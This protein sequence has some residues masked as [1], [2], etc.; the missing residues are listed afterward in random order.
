LIFA[1]SFE[2]VDGVVSADTRP[3]TAPANAR[4]ALNISTS[5]FAAVARFD[6]ACTDAAVAASD[7]VC[8]PACA[9]PTV[10][11]RPLMSRNMFPFETA[12]SVAARPVGSGKAVGLT[13]LTSGW[14]NPSALRFSV[15]AQG[16]TLRGRSSDPWRR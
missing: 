12:C 15:P 2:I 4:A 9:R 5:F 14:L 6:P 16:R 7:V 11:A 1:L 3:S 10:A 8:R 13:M